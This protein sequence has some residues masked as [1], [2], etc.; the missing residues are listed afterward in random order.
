MARKA[1]KLKPV[2]PPVRE[3]RQPV[4]LQLHTRGTLSKCSATS[5]LML[6]AGE[7]WRRLMDNSQDT[8]NRSNLPI[9][10]RVDNSISQAAIDG[11]VIRT[12]DASKESVARQQQAALARKN[13]GPYSAA[14][15][16]AIVCDDLEIDNAAIRLYGVANKITTTETRERLRTSLQTFAAAMRLPG[17]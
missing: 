7:H 11:R 5:R 14:V 3:R 4:L 17:T 16:D 9:C 12:I 2:L 6:A 1:T 10:A 8:G 13:I 15:L